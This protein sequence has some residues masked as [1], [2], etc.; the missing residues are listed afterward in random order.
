M[1]RTDADDGACLLAY[2][3]GGA[4]VICDPGNPDA[5]IRADRPVDPRAVEDHPVG[6][7]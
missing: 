1:H 2:E 5:W 3:E 6:E 7:G 4:V